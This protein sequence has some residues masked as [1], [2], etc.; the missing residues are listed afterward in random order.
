MKLTIYLDPD[1]V[2]FIK[3]NYPGLN[4]DFAET[5]EDIEY[6]ITSLVFSQ[7]TEEK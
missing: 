2:N 1:Q 5:R 7:I 3:K 4:S 6:V